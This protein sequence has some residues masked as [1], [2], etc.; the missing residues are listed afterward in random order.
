MGE[1]V[2]TVLEIRDGIQVHS[3]F[4]TQVKE[5]VYKDLLTNTFTQAD[6]ERDMK[7]GTQRHVF[8][9]LGPR[10]CDKYTMIDL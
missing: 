1:T 9:V 7:N 8:L 6:H 2:E 10:W 3:S 4:H 5:L